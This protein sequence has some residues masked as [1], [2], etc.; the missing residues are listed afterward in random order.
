M[1]NSS[2]YQYE[3]SLID[4]T[5]PQKQG[6]AQKMKFLIK[7]FF[8]KCNQIPSFLRIWS[9][10]LNKSLMKNFI[11]CSAKFN[12]RIC[13]FISIS[14]ITQFS[15]GEGIISSQT[16]PYSGSKKQKKSNCQVKNKII[17]MN[18]SFFRSLHSKQHSNI[19]DA[20][21]IEKLIFSVVYFTVRGQSIQLKRTK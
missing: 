16:N 13:N 14:Q 17:S 2:L 18:M 10:L 4:F 6:T 15:L 8:S 5:R 12:T 19:L 9:H 3:I 21:A 1:H 11:F 20:F 7:D